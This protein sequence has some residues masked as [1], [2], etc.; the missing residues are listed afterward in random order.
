MNQESA[1]RIL[2]RGIVTQGDQQAAEFALKVRL[3]EVFD[4]L[5]FEWVSR[6]SRPRLIEVRIRYTNELSESTREQV[7]EMFEDAIGHYG[8]IVLEKAPSLAETMRIAM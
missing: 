8:D 5:R 7:R 2:I 4:D 3:R 6:S 1:T